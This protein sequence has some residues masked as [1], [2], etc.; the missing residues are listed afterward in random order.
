MNSFYVIHSDPWSSNACGIVSDSGI[1]FVTWIPW[2]KNGKPQ[3]SCRVVFLWDLKNILAEVNPDLV[4]W[5]WEFRL[6]MSEKWWGIELAR[7]G[8]KAM[9][10]LSLMETPSLTQHPALCRALHIVGKHAQAHCL[11]LGSLLNALLTAG[12]F[13]HIINLSQVK[14][15][16]LL[17]DLI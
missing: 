13:G 2:P 9:Q 14:I 1:I 8:W 12:G 15:V 5:V 3:C 6:V 10:A 7:V 17:Q 4:W 16:Y 11:I